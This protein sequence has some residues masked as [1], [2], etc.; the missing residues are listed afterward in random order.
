MMQYVGRRLLL[1]VPTLLLMSIVVFIS[2]R[3]VPGGPVQVMLG[4]AQ[5]N[6]AA[7]ARLTRELGLNL[8]LWQQY[9]SW[10]AGVVR[11]DF[12]TSLFTGEGVATMIA[13][14]F[15]NTLALVA[16]SM[17][18]SIV[19][20]VV[21]GVAA[22]VH[23]GGWID[24]L[25]TFAAVLGVSLPGFWF[26]LMLILLFAV[27]LRWLPVAGAGGLRFLVLPAF[28]LGVTTAS[29]VAR[30]VRASVVE[31]L[32]EDYIR[33]A[34]AKG[35]SPLRVNYKHALR[36]ALIPVVTL[37]GLQVGG[38]LSG[39]FVV[40]S[41]FGYAGI[42]QLTVQALQERDFPVIQAVTLMVATI[43]VLVNLAVDIVY[44]AIDPR[45]RYE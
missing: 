18:I 21:G 28:T 44:S 6:P 43:Y 26:G 17:L 39:A 33:T 40:E 1:A 20:G 38:L 13:Q 45:I 36:N 29:V 5:T 7:V 35:L 41:V 15:P 27:D 8:P 25:V 34:R 23:K 12:G 31:A 30:F 3:L 37:V 2:V 22:A 11:G 9:A 14:R 42:G 4:L 16:S 32:R 24:L 19:L 10:L